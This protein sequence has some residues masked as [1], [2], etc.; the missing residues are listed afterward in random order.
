M[1][2]NPA[3]RA[4]LKKLGYSDEQIPDWVVKE[5][6]PQPGAEE[7][8]PAADDGPMQKP[9]PAGTPVQVGRARKKTS[10]QLARLNWLRLAP[11][12]RVHLNRSVYWQRQTRYL[13]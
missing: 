1:K 4:D 10:A 3:I 2:T 5:A 13:A 8:Q 11:L 12:T 7:S 9:K 6:E